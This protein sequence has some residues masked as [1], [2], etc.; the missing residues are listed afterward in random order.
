[1][2]LKLAKAAA[3]PGLPH[4]RQTYMRTWDYA[5]FVLRLPSEGLSVA[6]RGLDAPLWPHTSDSGKACISEV[7]GHVPSPLHAK[8]LETEEP[9][10]SLN[11][12]QPSCSQA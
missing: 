6:R 1:M 12:K 9:F 11:L 8:P 2:C 10:L 5:G 7:T 3:E 4:Y